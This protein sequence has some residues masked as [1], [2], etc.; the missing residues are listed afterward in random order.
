MGVQRPLAL[1]VAIVTGRRIVS[2]ESRVKVLE[3][4]KVRW[5]V[6]PWGAIAILL[7][8]SLTGMT[9]VWVRPSI[10]DAIL[11]TDSPGWARWIVYPLVIFPLYQIT[12]L[13]YGALL[14][15]FSFFWK[16][17]KAVGRWI[18]RAVT[19]RSSQPR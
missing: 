16:K 2:G 4:L 5:G 12:L 9:V 19:R 7:T 6:G 3:R 8:F 15:Q 10:L 1:M 13:A 14:G 18:V 11:P 17:E